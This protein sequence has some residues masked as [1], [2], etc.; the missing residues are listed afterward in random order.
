[1]PIYCISYKVYRVPVL[2]C[3][4]DALVGAIFVA[5]VNDVVAIEGVLQTRHAIT[6]KT[7]FL[8]C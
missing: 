5:I 2:I 4:F 1:M 3:V 7:V 6:D 8:S